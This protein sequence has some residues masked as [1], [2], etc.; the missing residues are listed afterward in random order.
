MTE[1]TEGIKK[2][3]TGVIGDDR[4]EALNFIR[5]YARDNLYFSGGSVLEA[6]RETDNQ[7]AH[8]RW[9]NKWGAV[10]SE[11]A[12]MGIM[13]KVGRMRATSK[14]SHTLTLVRWKSRIYM[15]KEV[16]EATDAQYLTDL[17]TDVHFGKM[18]LEDALLK[19]YEHGFEGG[20]NFDLG[21]KKLEKL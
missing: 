1:T 2:A 6:W 17:R 19:A 11:A 18:N 10:I 9:R 14:Q 12:K 8:N 21:L 3:L 16:K 20:V 5:E 4:F 13:H 15:G 7:V